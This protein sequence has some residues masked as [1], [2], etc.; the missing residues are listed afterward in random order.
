MS[1]DIFVAD[2][3]RSA[4]TVEDIPDDYVPRPIGPRTDIIARIKE[5][6]PSADFSEP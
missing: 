6:V 2:Y 4:R 3:P 5:E 1:W